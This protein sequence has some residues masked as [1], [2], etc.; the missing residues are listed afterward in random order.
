MITVNFLLD[1]SRARGI[2]DGT[3]RG[4]MVQQFPKD[5]TTPMCQEVPA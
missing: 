1:R 5:Q 4:A 2:S 3:D